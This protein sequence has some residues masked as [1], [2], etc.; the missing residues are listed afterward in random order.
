M[1]SLTNHKTARQGNIKNI[2]GRA[3]GFS[4]IELLVV[5]S[6][7]ALLLGILLPALNAARKRAKKVVCRSNMRQMGI[8]VQ[9]Y[10]IDHNNNLPP[11]SC[12]ITN[13]DDYW[14]KVLSDYTGEQ[15]LF[16]CPSDKADNFVDWS[17]PLEQ[18]KSRR[19]SSFAVNALLDPV[20]YRYKGDSNIYN[21]IDSIHKPMHCI[22]ISEAPNTKNFHLADHI[23][24]E[25]W[26]GSVEYAKKFIAWDRHIGK[27]NYLFVDGHAETLEFESTYAWPDKC[28]W[29]PESAPKWPENP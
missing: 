24:P 26:E 25:S 5:I 14:L 18:Q 15:L 3:Q 27:S 13:P 17:L 1:K 10:L 6:V 7:I 29:Y 20:N 16:R 21:S 12:H 22:W 19:Y 2:A 8:A 23:H 11:S 4:L 9:S 28:F